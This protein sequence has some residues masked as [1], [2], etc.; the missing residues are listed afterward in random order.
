MNTREQWLLDAVAELRPLFAKMAE[1]PDVHVS[2]SFP[3][4]GGLSKQWVTGVCISASSAADNKPQIY[5]NPRLTEIGGADGILGTLAHELV[6]ACGVIGHG[7]DF[8]KLARYI[9]LEGKMAS[10]TA[11]ESLQ[12]YFDQIIAKLGPMPHASLTMLPPSQRPD[13][14]RMKKCVCNSCGYTIRVAQKWI[15]IGIPMCPACD[16]RL[17][18]EE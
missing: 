2:I 18:I 16:T 17:L 13:K 1:V 14:C 15:S 6:H 3:P 4:K 7:K 9:G 11:N 12:R 10:S 5:I 8:G